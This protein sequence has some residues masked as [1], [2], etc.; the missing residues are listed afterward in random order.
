MGECCQQLSL[1]KPLKVSESKYL[2]S[3]ALYGVWKAEI[4]L[5]LGLINK[6]SDEEIRHI[7]LHELSH[8]KKADNWW[9]SLFTFVQII[10]WYNPLIWFFRSKTQEL[11]ELDCD[12]RVVDKL[13]G[14]KG[15]WFHS[16]QGPGKF[17]PQ[18]EP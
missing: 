5:P 1:I 17:I 10:N 18:E 11:Q 8:Y 14:Y 4:I 7:F 3:P 9:N 6:L 12:A 16:H 15:L 13:R 2:S